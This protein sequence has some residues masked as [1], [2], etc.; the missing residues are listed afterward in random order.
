MTDLRDRILASMPTDGKA[1]E[2]DLDDKRVPQALK[3]LAGAWRLTPVD[4]D[5]FKPPETAKPKAK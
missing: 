2:I 1:F 4:H 3:P 5:P